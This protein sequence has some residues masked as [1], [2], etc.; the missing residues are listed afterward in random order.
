[1]MNLARDAAGGRNW[2]GA[3]ADPFL[4]GVHASQNIIGIQSQGVIACAKH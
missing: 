1:M 3:G 4:Q 2:E